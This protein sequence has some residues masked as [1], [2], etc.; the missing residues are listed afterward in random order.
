MKITNQ[1]TTYSNQTPKKVPFKGWAAAPI[2]EIYL[3]PNNDNRF[4]P[5]IKELNKKC[6]RYFKII[7][8]LTDGLVAEPKKITLF[9]NGNIKGGTLCCW[10]QDNKIFFENNELG[11]F[12]DSHDPK[13]ARLL[14][15]Q[16][17]VKAKTMNLE[18]QG[19]NYFLGKKT[20]GENYALVGADS[21]DGCE[22]QHIAKS[23]NVKTENMYAIS[24]PNFHIDMVVRPLTY[25]Y[26]LVG[27]PKLTNKL[28]NDIRT[29]K[30]LPLLEKHHSNV[31]K[32]D[33]HY[34]YS[35]TAKTVKELKAHGF[36]PI[37]VPGLL[38]DEMGLNFMNAIV[39]QKPDGK[40][41]YITNKTHLGENIGIDFEA[42]FEKDL[43]SK[44][45]AIEKVIYIDGEG[46][47]QESLV[48]Y[49]GGTHCMSC[50]KPDFEKWNNLLK[51]PKL[52]F[53]TA[54]RAKR[55]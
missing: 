36:K 49:E 12:Y 18:S 16:L 5:L 33:E 39:H 44:F 50:E 41:I 8:Q 6:K 17:Q 25:P 48:E 2:K 43:K 24:Q 42:I 55:L 9:K 28:I 23:L 47:I 31:V 40:L 21:L 19:G 45:P 13:R 3:Q 46:L 10:S 15:K 20:N 32:G 53:P 29:K 30:G 51:T 11:V 35:S 27:D 34:N 37:R 7:V 26:V 38:S 14:A 22:G 4:M 1:H 54:N 52:A